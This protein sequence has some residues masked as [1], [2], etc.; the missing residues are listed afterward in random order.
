MSTCDVPSPPREQPCPTCRR[1]LPR[2]SAYFARDA[3]GR[4]GLKRRCR[5]CIN[6]AERRRYAASSD[7]VRERVRLRRAQRTELFRNSP[8]WQPTPRHKADDQHGSSAFLV[9]AERNS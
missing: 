4:Q 6:A 8:Q 7:A 1:Q 2:T 3:M 9:S 5:D